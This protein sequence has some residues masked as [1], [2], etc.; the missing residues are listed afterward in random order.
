MLVAL[1]ML[2]AVPPPVVSVAQIGVTNVPPEH[3]VMMANALVTA[4]TERGIR[5]AEEGAT[6]VLRGRLEKVGDGTEGTFEL[7]VAGGDQVVGAW[8]ASVGSERQIVDVAEE[9]GHRVRILLVG[10]EPKKRS[11]LRWVPMVMGGAALVGS[12]A[13]YAYAFSEHRRLV[14][15]DP[16]INSPERAEAFA[17]R[18]KSIETTSYLL[19]GLGLGLL[20]AGALFAFLA[21]ESDVRVGAAWV[22]GPALALQGALP[23]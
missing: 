20:A 12:V 13:L 15:G 14:N 11:F 19:G 22:N 18:G 21:P 3:G 5:V 23:W 10:E 17:A 8:V 6:H 16:S 2:A 1:L 4:L 9:I 7:V